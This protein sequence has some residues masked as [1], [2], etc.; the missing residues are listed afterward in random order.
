[1]NAAQLLV[2]LFSGVIV[3]VAVVSHP[4]SRAVV[5]G[6]IAGFIVSVIVLD[7]ADGYLNWAEHFWA[8]T[9]KFA[10]FWIAVTAGILTGAAVARVT[11]ASQAR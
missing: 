8:E 9:A 6:L 3:G 7:G 11:R 10:T 4:F 5:I 2:G 1:M